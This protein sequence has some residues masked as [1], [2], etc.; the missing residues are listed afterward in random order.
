MKFRIY[1]MLLA[2]LF[3]TYTISA[4]TKHGIEFIEDYDSSVHTNATSAI[5]TAISHLSTSG[6]VIEFGRGTYPVYSTFVIP[7]NITLRGGG[8]GTIVKGMSELPIFKTANGASWVQIQNMQIAYDGSL[9]TGASFQIEG[10]NSINLK[11]L[12]V[13]L[14]APVGRKFAGIRIWNGTDT[15][16]GATGFMT[17]IENCLIQQGL[18]WLKHSDSRILN[19]FIWASESLSVL[20]YAIRIDKDAGNISI[21]GNDIV[22]SSGNAGGI[23]INGAPFIRIENNF[24][25]GND[26]ASVI[27]NTAIYGISC[28]F[29]VISDNVFCNLIQGGIY[30]KDAHHIIIADNQF[31]DCNRASNS[32]ND[33]IKI[34]SDAFMANGIIIHGNNHFKS[35]ARTYGVKAVNIIGSYGARAQ[36]NENTAY[37]A[38]GGYSAPFFVTNR[39]D[40]Y[41][42]IRNN[43]SQVDLNSRSG[44]ITSQ[45]GTVNVT[46]SPA[47]EVAPKPSEISFQFIGANSSSSAV[48]SIYNVT[49]SGFSMNVNP[50]SS[51]YNVNGTIYWACELK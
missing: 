14:T 16:A 11:V 25:D 3:A 40:G 13:F 29:S 42:S 22:P 18:I 35:S 43:R 12:N 8:W 45:Q 23:Y 10:V 28:K 2:S 20:P 36:V 48:I 34:R 1:A 26:R 9:K 41:S 7:N 4:Q 33:D 47:F 46:F 17:H 38:Q 30:L 15:A 21:S 49:A 44:S 24:F 6:G 27:T 37:A 32:G 19:N 31:Y 50:L 5:Q 39:S 51:S